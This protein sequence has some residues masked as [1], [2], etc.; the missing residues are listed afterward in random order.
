MRVVI[1]P[2]GGV[3]NNDDAVKA[4]SE[5]ERTGV[6]ADRHEGIAA[7]VH[8]RP[9]GQ[10]PQGGHHVYPAY[11]LIVDPESA[12]ACVVAGGGKGE[13]EDVSAD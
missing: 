1:D 9:L 11:F 3:E 6:V 8:A 2:T 4:S 12:D 10:P 5:D 7:D 13:A